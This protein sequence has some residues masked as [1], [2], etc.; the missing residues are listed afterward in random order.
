MIRSIFSF[1]VLSAP[2]PCLYSS[3]FNIW[4]DLVL[5]I[6]DPRTEVAEEANS[7]IDAANERIRSLRR[8]S[9][10]N[11][12]KLQHIGAHTLYDIRLRGYTY[13]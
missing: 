9:L 2:I 11:I 4:G 1:M 7:K 12:G 10:R 5:P 8:R 13:N 3:K 6:W